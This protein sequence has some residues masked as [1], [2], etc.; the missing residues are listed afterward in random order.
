MDYKLHEYFSFRSIINSTEVGLMFTYVA[1]SFAGPL[2]V[3]MRCKLFMQVAWL[4]QFVLRFFAVCPWENRH[5]HA[6]AAI[7]RCNCCLGGTMN[8]VKKYSL[9]ISRGIQAL[10]S[11]NQLHGNWKTKIL[12][13]DFTSC[14]PPFSSRVS[15][16]AMFNYQRTCCSYDLWSH[17][18]KKGSTKNADPSNWIAGS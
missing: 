13:D 12:F 3:S 8:N 2:S 5:C 14:K 1:I 10:P 17:T 18:G 4:R 6:C 16:L 9:E 15:Q 11:K 7:G